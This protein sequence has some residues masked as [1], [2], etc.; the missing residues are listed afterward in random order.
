M[1]TLTEEL[2]LVID[3]DEEVLV[4]DSLELEDE[5]LVLVTD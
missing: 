1:V 5:E 2:V 4:T 3:I